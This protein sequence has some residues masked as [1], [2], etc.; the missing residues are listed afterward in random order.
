MAPK[1]SIVVCG[2]GITLG[3]MT[4]ET[5]NHIKTSDIVLYV[6]TDYVTES[7]I[8]ENSKSSESMRDYYEEG[9]GRILIYKRMID[10]VMDCARSGLKTCAIFYGHPGIFVTPSHEIIKLAQAENIS[11]RML[12]GISAEDCLYADLGFDPGTTGCTAYEA[13]DF[14]LYKRKVDTSAWLIVWQPDS[15]GD[16]YHTS[17]RD[18]KYRLLVLKKYLNEFYPLDTKIAIYEANTYSVGKPKIIWDILDNFEN[19]EMSGISTLVIPPISNPVCDLS[20][21][22]E[23]GINE[24]IKERKLLEIQ[25]S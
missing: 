14:L 24:A 20:I 12:P 25:Y 7:W 4:I 3:Q 8:K 21:A 1:G 2:S 13:T 17:N 10:R 23:L 9:K 5:L 15:V 22:K 19:I 18:N 6:L 11:A 16:L